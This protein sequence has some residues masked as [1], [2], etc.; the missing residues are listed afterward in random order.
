MR[1]NFLICL[2]ISVPVML[3]SQKLDGPFQAKEAQY[4]D[5]P[6]E[7]LTGIQA[8]KLFK[9]GYWLTSFFGKQ[10]ENNSGTGGG[11]YRTSGNKYIET[12]WYYS[13]DS[14]ASGQTYTFDYS[15]IGD[16]YRQKGYIN[17]DK[18]KNYLIDER[19]VRL[20]TLIPLKDSSLEGAWLM[21][22]KTDADSEGL[23]I[24]AYPSFQC[25][26][27][28]KKTK[29]FIGSYGGRYWYDG[30]TLIEH[31]DFATFE[32]AIGT[33][34]QIPI[35]VKNR[36]FIHTRAGSTKPETWIKSGK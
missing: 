28:N 20:T 10:G 25:S 13:W 5:E 18:Y 31:I 7:V 32:V 26:Y 8:V 27:F 1:K 11:T 2:L 22:A 17:S 29:K 35:T 21:E 14:T 30:K 19:Q 6:M 36:T 23:R 33:D 16:E 24:Y 12:L 4:G 34:A 15:L 9:D 3:F